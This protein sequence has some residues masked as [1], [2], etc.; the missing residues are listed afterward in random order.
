[1][2]DNETIAGSFE[3]LKEA[4]HPE[5][6]QGVNK[7]I[8]FEFSGREPGRVEHYREQ[9]GLLLRPGAGRESRRNRQG[10]F[11]RLASRAHRQAQRG[12]RLH[13]WQAE[14]LA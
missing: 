13:G 10:G 12:L 4:F 11:G 7:T 9:W 8:Q 1:M 6:T 3:A 2:A 5:K 14:S